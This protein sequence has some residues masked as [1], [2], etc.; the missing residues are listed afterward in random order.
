MVEPS[1]GRSTCDFLRVP[2]IVRLESNS[3][4]RSVHASVEIKIKFEA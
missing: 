3:E 2:M 4:E 1:R